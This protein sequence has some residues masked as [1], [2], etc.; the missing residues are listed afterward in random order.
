MLHVARFDLS[1]FTTKPNSEFIILCAFI[2]TIG[3]TR[4]RRRIHPKDAGQ[5]TKILIMKELQLFSTKYIYMR[6]QA[7]TS[8]EDSR[9]ELGA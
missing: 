6:A 7:H 4:K 5:K 9:L 3:F 8:F 1:W 2:N